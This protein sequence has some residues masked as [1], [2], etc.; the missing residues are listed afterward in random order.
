[1]ATALKRNDVEVKLGSFCTSS[2]DGSRSLNELVLQFM[3][4]T[5][6]GTNNIG[7]KKYNQERLKTNVNTEINAE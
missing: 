7:L 5:S 4:H 1:M 2:Q 6:G 3:S